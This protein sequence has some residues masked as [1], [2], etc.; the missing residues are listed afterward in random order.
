MAVVLVVEDDATLLDAVAYNLQRDGHQVHTAADGVLGL[1]MARE[2][3]PDLIVLDLMLPRMSGL[4]VCRLVRN[5]QPVPILILTARDSEQDVISGLDLGADDYVTKP[6]SMR[7]L[8]SRV[9]ALL[10]RDGLSRDAGPREDAPNGDV[11]VAGDLVVDVGKH[12]VSKGGMA[13]TLR[14]REFLLLEYLMRHPG[15]VLSRDLILERVWGYTYAGESRTVDV[16]VRWLREKLE[17]EPSAP[18]HI[19]TVRGFGYRFAP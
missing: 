12:E 9:N 1:A 8:R 3:H 15:Q 16:H 14:P 2:E 5:E 11:L 7:E 18:R 13:V 17:D 6:F 10:R 4:D 19:E